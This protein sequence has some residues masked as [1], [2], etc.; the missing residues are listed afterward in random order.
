MHVQKIPGKNDHFKYNSHIGKLE[1]SLP[2][3]EE[4]RA[5]EALEEK[6]STK[7]KLQ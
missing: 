5:E 6:Q 3:P 2:E 4:E 1:K 7:E